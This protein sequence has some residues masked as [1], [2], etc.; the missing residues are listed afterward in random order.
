MRSQLLQQNLI[1]WLQDTRSG[2]F[3]Q[4]NNG[5][6]YDP[7]QL[8]CP[9]AIFYGTEDYLADVS[10]VQTLIATAGKIVAVN[11]LMYSGN[12][13]KTHQQISGFAHMDFTWSYDAAELVYPQVI[14]LLNKFN[15]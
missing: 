2:A 11:D 14:Q 3:G 7:S 12:W 10:D 9:I 4:Y 8:N 6:N 15:H 13:V 5:P 1:H